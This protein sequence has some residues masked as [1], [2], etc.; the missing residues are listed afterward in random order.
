VN[1]S[2]LY[3]YPDAGERAIVGEKPVDASNQAL[4]ALR[5]RGVM[6]DRHFVARL[7]KQDGSAGPQP[8]DPA[9]GLPAPAGPRTRPGPALHDPNIW[10]S[11]S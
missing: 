1:E 9:P 2:R 5:Y 7:R 10:E 11:F 4:D 3:R 8:A 6:I